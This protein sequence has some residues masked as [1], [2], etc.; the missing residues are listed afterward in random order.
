MEYFNKAR[1]ILNFRAEFV[2]IVC[3]NEE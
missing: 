2:P 1:M 3:V